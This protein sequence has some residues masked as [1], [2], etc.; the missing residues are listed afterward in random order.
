MNWALLLID[1]ATD[2][3]QLCHRLTERPNTEGGAD[4][5]N[6]WRGK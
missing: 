3:S 5:V 2:Q 6:D 1:V 4:S